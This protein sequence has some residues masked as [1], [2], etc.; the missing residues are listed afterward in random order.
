MRCV[1]AGGGVTERRSTIEWERAAQES[2]T[3]SR[4]RRTDPRV[5]PMWVTLAVGVVLAVIFAVS[6]LAVLVATGVVHW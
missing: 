1:S 6:S 2:L 4:D 3:R 5:T